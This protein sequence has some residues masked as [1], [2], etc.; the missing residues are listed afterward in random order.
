MS[1]RRSS[2]LANRLCLAL[3]ER[4]DA[5]V[6]TA[7]STWGGDGPHPADPLRLVTSR[8]MQLCA[9][10]ACARGRPVEQLPLSAAGES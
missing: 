3:A 6:L 1:G 4:Q 2:R 8:R 10:R 5:P 9:H 7:G